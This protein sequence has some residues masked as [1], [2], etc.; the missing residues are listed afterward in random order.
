M[1]LNIHWIGCAQGNFAPG[2]GGMKPEA[3]IIHLADGSLAGTDTWFLTR[4]EKR[5]P[6]GFPSSA[7]YGIGKDG[8]IHQYV[9]DEDRAYHAGRVLRAT[10]VGLDAHPNVNPNSFCLG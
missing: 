8:T 1:P 2:R 10:W 4:P 6:A 9:K 3:F 5:T 7:H